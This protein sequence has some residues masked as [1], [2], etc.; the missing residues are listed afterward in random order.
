MEWVGLVLLAALLLGGAAAVAG[1]GADGRSFGGFLTHRLACAV[2][3]GC[4]DGDRRLSARYGLRDAA[5]IRRHAP[6]LVYE[7]GER[8]LPVD[9]RQ[10]RA[11]RCAEGPDDRD[12]DT[13]RTDSGRHATAYTRLVRR[14]GRTYLQY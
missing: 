6:G 7:P 8:Q 2:R 10:C 11:R 13:H 4:D 14:G 9:W 12:L 3:G 1:R 5:L